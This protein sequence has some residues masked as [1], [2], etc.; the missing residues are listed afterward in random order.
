[1]KIDMRSIYRFQPIEYSGALPS[2]GD[3]Y[4]ECECGD[5]VS[6]VSFVKAACTCG[7]LAGGQGSVTVQSAEKVKPLR[8]KLR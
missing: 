2:G 8:G 7:N 1:M 4:Y 3:V 6:S 5:I